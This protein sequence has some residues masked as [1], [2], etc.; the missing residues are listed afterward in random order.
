MWKLVSFE[1]G[2]GGVCL[3]FGQL[4]STVGRG[5]NFGQLKSTVR[6]GLYFT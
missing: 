2:G 1:W 6:V 3:N 4:K 5:L